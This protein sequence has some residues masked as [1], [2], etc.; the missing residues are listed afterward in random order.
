MEKSLLKQNRYRN[1]QKTLEELT[2]TSEFYTKNK[3][4]NVTLSSPL[5]NITK[6]CRGIYNHASRHLTL[7]FLQKRIVVVNQNQNLLHGYVYEHLTRRDWAQSAL[8]L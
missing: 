7:T 8:C 6:I 1:K 2:Q 3:F 5:T 4:L